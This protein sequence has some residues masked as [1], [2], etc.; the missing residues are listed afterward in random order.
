MAHLKRNPKMP[1][2]EI[3]IF[4]SGLNRNLVNSDYNLRVFECKI[5]AWNM[6]VYQHQL[7]KTFDKTLFRDIP[8]ETFEATRDVMPH[9]FQSEQNI[10]ILSIDV[11][12]WT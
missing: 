7:L 8:R 1:E 2:F 4:F 3:G 9:S 12:V 5:A 6:L 11:Y 10:S